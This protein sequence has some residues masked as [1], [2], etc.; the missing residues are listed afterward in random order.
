MKPILFFLHIPKTA[1]TSLYRIFARQY[2]GGRLVQAYPPLAEDA[3]EAAI[4]AIGS[5]AEVFY[6][7]LNFG[8]HRLLGVPGR[9]LSMLR[10]PVDRVASY[11]NHQRT[12]P[13]AEH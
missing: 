3:R 7:H 10:H 2:P 12:H 9:Y 13:H 1:G 6:G 5:G 4:A 8:V 11:L